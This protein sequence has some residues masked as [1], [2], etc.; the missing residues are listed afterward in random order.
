MTEREMNALE[1]L[2]TAAAQVVKNR[3]FD[4]LNG[5]LLDA[6]KEMKDARREADGGEEE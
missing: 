4:P 5:V 1:Q 2:L 3:P 6:I